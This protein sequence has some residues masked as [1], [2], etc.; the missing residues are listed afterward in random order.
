[1]A[2]IETEVAVMKERIAEIK[3]DTDEIK[4]LLKESVKPRLLE[5]DKDIATL[6]A[7]CGEIRPTVENHGEA[8]NTIKSDVAVLQNNW[9][10][11]TSITA[12]VAGAVVFVIDHFLG[13]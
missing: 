7:Q 12:F 1:M 8:I 5:H 6:K 11:L 13:G 10:I 9:M 2:S 3:D 4:A